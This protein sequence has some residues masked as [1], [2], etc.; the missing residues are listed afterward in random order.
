MVGHD[1]E[2][3]ELVGT[4]GAVVLEGFEE[5][6]GVRRNLKEAAAIVG[7][8]GDRRMC[9]W[10]RFSAGLPFRGSI[11]ARGEGGEASLQ[12]R[13]SAGGAAENWHA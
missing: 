4:S 13:G 6:F 8:A 10:W 9:R 5:E 3:V 12:Q 11:G 1:D 2:D 7:D